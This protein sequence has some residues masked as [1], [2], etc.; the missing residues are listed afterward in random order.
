MLIGCKLP[1]YVVVECEITDLLWNTS[2]E[3][4]YESTEAFSSGEFFEKEE[5]NKK[6]GFL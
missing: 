2:E 6:Q 3:G 5:G 1:F 4:I